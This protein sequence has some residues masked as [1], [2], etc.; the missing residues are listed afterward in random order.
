MILGNH[1]EKL[2]K[3]KKQI[4]KGGRRNMEIPNLFNSAIRIS[5][6][7]IRNPPVGAGPRAC[8]G[9][10]QPRGVAPTIDLPDVLIPNHVHGNISRRGRPPCLPNTGPCV[11]N[12]GT[13]NVLALFWGNHEGLPLRF[14]KSEFPIVVTLRA[15][16]SPLTFSPDRGK[17]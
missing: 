12:V 2:R 11:I 17:L 7:A 9:F 13:F 14:F 6:S 5:Q 10:G 16:Q 8:P 15:T 1:Q 4:A 3:A